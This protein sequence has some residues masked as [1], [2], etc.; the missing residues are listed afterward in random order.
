VRAG[1]FDSSSSPHILRAAS[2]RSCAPVD[3]SR[4]RGD[5]A[6]ATLGPR[7]HSS[8]SRSQRKRRP[9]RR[10][11]PRAASRSGPAKPCV[12]L[13]P[14]RTRRERYSRP[15]HASSSL[16]RP[17]RRL[18][19]AADRLRSAAQLEQRPATASS[20]SGPALVHLILLSTT[21]RAPAPFPPHLTRRRPH[22]IADLLSPHLHVACR[23]SID[24]LTPARHGPCILQRRREG[25]REGVHPRPCVGQFRLRLHLECLS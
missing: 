10:D 23:P 8:A 18:N 13:S 17:R 4:V 3:S 19:L 25:Q 12:H 2:I 6:G 20:T 14:A 22:L 24:R 7:L 21:R 16:A 11:G 1:G 15:P 9:L 5:A